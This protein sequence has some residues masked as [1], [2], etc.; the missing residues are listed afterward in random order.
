MSV[1]ARERCVKEEGKER[2]VKDGEENVFFLKRR[3]KGTVQMVS[4]LCLYLC[5]YLSFLNVL[6]WFV[7]A[8]PYG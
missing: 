3:Y 8:L 4:L 1:V 6:I 7:F 5:V 2:Y